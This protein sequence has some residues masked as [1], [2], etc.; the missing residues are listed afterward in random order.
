MGLKYLKL[1]K[2]RCENPLAIRLSL[3]ATHG[4]ERSPLWL[5]RFDRITNHPSTR[6]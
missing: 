2:I 4:P 3:S 1:F 5:S 6:A